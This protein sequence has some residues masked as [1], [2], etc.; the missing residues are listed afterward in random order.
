MD[1]PADWG[2]GEPR[3]GV[4]GGPWRR[5][6]PGGPADWAWASLQS[7]R[8]EPRLHVFCH[9]NFHLQIFLSSLNGLVRW[10]MWRPGG[11]VT[12]AGILCGGAGDRD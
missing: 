7:K 4:G 9:P 5:G 1:A 8:P 12:D 10:N 3:D 11:C 6:L 2:V